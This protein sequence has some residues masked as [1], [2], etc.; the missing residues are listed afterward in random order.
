MAEEQGEFTGIQFVPTSQGGIASL[1]G[2]IKIEGNKIFKLP[3]T[4]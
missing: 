2:V 3:G 4:K 1:R